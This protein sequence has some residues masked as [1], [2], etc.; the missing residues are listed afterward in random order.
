MS[1]KQSPS[2]YGVSAISPC[3]PRFYYINII[4]EKPTSAH[5]ALVTLKV[6]L[7]KSLCIQCIW[8]CDIWLFL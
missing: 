2:H 5:G 8:N 6:S 3:H 7:Y 4:S 1:K